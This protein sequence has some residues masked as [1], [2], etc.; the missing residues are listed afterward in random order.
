MLTRSVLLF[1]ELVVLFFS[2]SFGIELLQRWVGPERLRAWMG[3]HP[4]VAA[5]KGITI[6][7]ITPF[8]TYSAIPM[9]VGMRQ[10]AVPPAGYV[11]FIVAAPVLDPILFGAL[12]FIVGLKV[13]AIYSVVAFVGAMSLALLAQHVGI[14]RHL[15]P[16]SAFTNAGRLPVTTVPATSPTAGSAPAAPD[17]CEEG[18]CGDDRRLPWSGLRLESAHAAQAATRLLRSVGVLLVAGVSVGLAIEALVPAET[19]ATITGN[20]SALSIPTAAALGIPLYF[21]T[22][23]FIPI[24]D[25]LNE[26]G[27]GIGSIVALTIAGAGASIPEFMILTRLA[28][29]RLIAALFLYV[30]AVAVTGGFLAQ[31]LPS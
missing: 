9:L 6:G 2:V 15:K 25:S 30:F 27:V 22:G 19:A 28:R 17:Q 3:G 20:N 24:A 10:A 4:A 11:A 29:P 5:L 23:L 16:L 12:V 13:A 1:V 18:S 8:C 7:F 21:H 31:A 14:E 26:A